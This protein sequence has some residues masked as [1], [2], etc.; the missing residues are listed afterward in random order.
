MENHTYII[1]E[2]DNSSSLIHTSHFI[3]NKFLVEGG[4]IVKVLDTNDYEV[5]EKEYLKYLDK[6]F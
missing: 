6:S 3:K 2:D 5:A 4:K 1:L